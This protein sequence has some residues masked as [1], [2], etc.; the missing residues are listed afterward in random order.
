MN[1]VILLSVSIFLFACMVSG[2]SKGLS[3]SD[4]KFDGPLGCEGATIEEVGKNHFKLIPGHAPNHPNWP[5]MIQFEITGN[6]KGNS[7][8]LDVDFPVKDAHYHF[9]D[10]FNSWSY[11]NEHWTPV[12][13]LKYQHADSRRSNVM[14]FPEFTE[15]KVYV[16]HQ[17]PLSF[18]KLETI[19]KEWGNHPAVKVNILGKSIEGR[20][21]YRLTVTNQAV[22]SQKWVHYFT[23]QHPGEHN[24]QW[25]M[26]G[27]M[28][29]LLEEKNRAVLNNSICHFVFMMSPDG[30]SNG[31]YRT[32]AQG[33][34]GNRSYFYKGADKEKQAHEAYICQKDLEGLMKSKNPVTD[35][36]SMHTWQGAVEP[37]LIK[38]PEIGKEVGEWE[39]F[40]EILIKNDAELLIEP[41][42]VNNEPENGNKAYWTYGPHAQFGITTVL[43]EG[44][45]NFYTKEKNME[46][47]KILIKSIFEYYE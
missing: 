30:P 44:A 33:V 4:F 21:I 22:K 38:G 17:V 3:V 46:S 19:I 16:G 28:E 6:A 40:R 14:V 23:N 11:D 39:K 20:N 12:Q 8:R 18:E 32:N 9:D 24:A 31:W 5:N 47:G 10:Y 37:I 27:L 2:Q 15:D 7:L 34:D 36:W 41:L 45:G 43:C 13:W 26:V 25:R 29:W 35:L 42:R 1:K